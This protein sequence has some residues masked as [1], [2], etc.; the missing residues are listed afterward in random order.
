MRTLMIGDLL[1]LDH[2]QQVCGLVV[3]FPDKH[4]DTDD[5]FGHKVPFGWTTED[6]IHRFEI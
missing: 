3:A 1:Q 6:G 5:F 4:H 2:K